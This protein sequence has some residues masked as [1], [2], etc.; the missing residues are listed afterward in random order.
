MAL[1]C[2]SCHH[3]GKAEEVALTVSSKSIFFFGTSAPVNQAYHLESG[4]I[5]I[6]ADGQE[7]IEL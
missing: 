2:L 4:Q 6:P 7:C 3:G 5:A 1:I